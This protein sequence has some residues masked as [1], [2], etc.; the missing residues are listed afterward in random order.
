MS[1]KD[2]KRPSKP[3]AQQNQGQRSNDFRQAGNNE[4]TPIYLTE[5]S[6]LQTPEEHQRDQQ[7][8]PREDNRTEVNRDD[9]HE[10]RLGRLTG[11]DDSDSDKA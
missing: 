8:D 3:D 9:L 2:E 10:I 6:T 5:N 11:R 4:E 7:T 1:R